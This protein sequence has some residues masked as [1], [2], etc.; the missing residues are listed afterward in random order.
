MKKI[1][2][3]DSKGFSEKLNDYIS[4]NRSTNLDVSEKVKIILESIICEGDK[5]LSELTFKYDN[6]DIMK[7]GIC[8]DKKDIDAAYRE[9]EKELVDAIEKAADRISA[10]H[11]R[12][13]P[14]NISY[15]D[16]SNVQLA[17]RWTPLDSVGLYVPGGKASYPS[18]VIMT[19][20]PAKTAKVPEVSM[21]VPCPKGYL[22][23]SILV[24]AKVCGVEKIYKIGGAQAIAAMAYGTNT[25]KK[26]NKIFGPGNAWVAEAKR[27]LFGKVGIDMIAGPS[28]ILVISDNKSD[29]NWIAADLLSQAE[30][31]TESQSIL[32][33]DNLDFAKNVENA[34]NSL[35][36]SLKR[37]EIAEAS[38]NNNGIIIVIEDLMHS[39]D[40]INKIAPEHL[41]ISVDNP[42]DIA[43]KINNAGSIFLGR[44]VP[45]AIGDY[46]AGPNHVL[47]TA[48]TARFS[49]GIS[50]IDY[51]RRTSLI[52]CD[53]GALNEIA[54]SAI[55]IAENEGLDA[56]A[57][58]MKIRM[59]NFKNEK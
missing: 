34:I 2:N 51:M 24:A 31:D 36:K 42:E 7:E 20:I 6:Y 14:N 15:K 12:Q 32:I 41:E 17:S 28:E 23:P 52:K 5:A 46:I 13:L 18:S 19:A 53:S 3:F 47:P 27:Q 21:C 56:H 54:P 1:L 44:F 4:N 49:S 45:E 29:P 25:V 35:I 40:I 55:K 38:W 22:N 57:L 37:K 26:V 33:T 59:N 58:S 10:F 16:D 50:T 30:H 43:K 8:V 39:I 9:C 11:E 48:R